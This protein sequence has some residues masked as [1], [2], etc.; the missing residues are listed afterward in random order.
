MTFL[1]KIF[2]LIRLIDFPQSRLRRHSSLIFL[3]GGRID[4][5]SAVALSVRE[6]LLRHLPDPNVMGAAQIILAERATAALP[7]SNF[8]NL[9][10]LEEYLSALVDAVVLFL[11]SAGSRCELGAFVKTDEIRKKLVVVISNLHNNSPSF[12]TLGVLKYFKELS[13]IEAEIYPFDWNILD[14][15]VEIHDYVLEGIIQDTSE[16]IKRIRPKSPFDFDSL[17]D[18]INLTLAFCHFLRGAKISE[19]K[20]CFAIA[21][22]NISESTIVKHLSVLEICRFI[23]PVSHG[24]KLRFY[25][26]LISELPI[27][28][29]FTKYAEDRQRNILRWIQEISAL[30]L[31][32]D[33]VRMRIFQEHQHGA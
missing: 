25:I 26:P 18:R 11:E 17:G 7:G 29:S 6:A 24:R 19:I 20:Q 8:S 32:Q 4:R 12:I 5:N 22:H 1:E 27:R 28:F 30:I 31:E 23:R 15:G 2:E 3:C 33:S 10:D 14:P 9:L 13:K 16:A 21:G